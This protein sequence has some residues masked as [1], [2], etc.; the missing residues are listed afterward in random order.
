MPP[1]SQNSLND[2]LSFVSKIM[3]IR[4]IED[5]SLVSHQSKCLKAIPPPPP[6]KK[7]DVK[8]KVRN[9]KK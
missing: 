1:Q 5:L 7:V 9:E 2:F 8:M 4:F 3:K 6:L